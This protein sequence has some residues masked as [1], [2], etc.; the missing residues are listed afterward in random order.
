MMEMLAKTL[1]SVN[2]QL[3]KPSPKTEAAADGSNMAAN[4]VSDRRGGGGAKSAEEENKEY[5]SSLSAEQ[6]NDILA[7]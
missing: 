3:I 2:S 6:V 5:L 4:P 7:S 1:E